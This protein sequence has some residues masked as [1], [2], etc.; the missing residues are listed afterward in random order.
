MTKTEFIESYGAEWA[1]LINRPVFR[2]FVEMCNEE[3]ASG[4]AMDT[5][6]GDAVIYGQVLFAQVQGF[7]RWKALMRECAIVSPKIP[8]GPD[9]TEHP[10]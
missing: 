5:K 1:K 10:V 4:T 8:A 2:A 6:P 7:Q 9:Y 3:S